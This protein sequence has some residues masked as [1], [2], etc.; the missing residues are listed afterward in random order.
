MRGL[1]A[2]LFTALF[3][4]PA[5]AAEVGEERYGYP[6]NVDGEVVF[7]YIPRDLAER[8][9]DVVAQVLADAVPVAEAIDPDE[10]EATSDD[11]D[12]LNKIQGYTAFPYYPILVAELQRLAEEHPGKMRLTSAGESRLGLDLWLVEIADFDNP[13]RRP[14]AEREVM[15]LDG[16]THSNEYSGVYFVTEWLQFLLD[17]FETNDTARWIVENR[18][19]FVLPMV[20]PDGSHAFGRV[21]AIDV[22]INRNFPG[23]W[24]TVAE[25]PVLNWPG[26]YPASEPETQAVINVFQD[27]RPDFVQSTHCC[28]NLWLHPYGAEQLGNA[29]DFDMYTNICHHV[30]PDLTVDVERKRCGETWSTIYPASGTTLDEG[31][32]QVGA[33]SWTYEMSGRGRVVGPWGEPVIDRDPRVQEIESWRGVLHGFLHAEKYGALP[34]VVDVQGTSDRLT[35]TVENQGWGNITQATL[36]FGAH[37]IALPALEP[38]QQAILTLQGDFRQDK[39][40]VELEWKKRMHPDSNWGRVTYDI[41]LEKSGKALTGLLPALPMAP[42]MGDLLPQT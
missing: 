27:V 2:A 10:L 30:F 25:M 7:P 40:P 3:L 24:G 21:N 31:Y 41:V 42:S 28:G 14:L 29:P 39:V 5:V 8:H 9:P 33:S 26:P 22:N 36:R 19:T 1:V 34:R 38:G 4:V 15:Y 17:E 12:P 20:N 35:V 18:H 32:A 6:V 11:P 37:G 16:G 13:E 23:T